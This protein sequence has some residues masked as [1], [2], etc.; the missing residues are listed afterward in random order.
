MRHRFV[1]DHFFAAE[2]LGFHDFSRIAHEPAVKLYGPKN[3]SLPMRELKRKRNIIHLDPRHTFKTT[4]KRVDRI[5]LICAYSEEITILNNSATQPLA[6]KV[7]I[8]TAEAFY[9]GW[10]T[11]DLHRL[12]PEL[13]VNKYPGGE[14]NTPNRRRSGPG[15]LDPTLA[16]TS[17]KTSQSGWHPFFMDFDDVEDVNN[18]G[19]G[20]DDGVRQHVIDVCDQNENLVRDGGFIN[21]GGTRYHPFDYYGKCLDRAMRNPEKWDFLV[22]ASLIVKSGEKLVPGEFPEPDD[23]ILNFPEFA[24]LSYAELREKYEANF[25]SFMCQQQ[26]DPQGGHVVTFDEKLYESCLIE[27]ERVPICGGETLVCWRLPYSGNDAMLEAEGVAARIVNGKVYIIDCWKGNYIPSRLAERM[28]QSFKTHEAEAMMVL[29]TPGSG[30]MA[31]HI[32][33]EAARRNVGIGRIR[34][35]EWEESD[36][37]RNA[38]I[39]ALEPLLKVG[40][41]LFSTAMTR[42]QECRKQF[43]HFGLVPDNGIIECVSKMADRVPVSQMRA[44]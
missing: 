15:D 40:R 20:V 43:V 21:I 11:M 6:E 35:V 4:L 29:E 5:M 34:W 9:C 22:R 30:Y 23:I 13:V 3:P 17:P 10:G 27:E 24:N 38:A 1:T 41:V 16:F 32:R 25:E 2:M 39:K 26:N 8:K 42:W 12:F 7:S 37:R 31:P 18:S 19:I 28:V 36:D 33:N 14:W 44:G